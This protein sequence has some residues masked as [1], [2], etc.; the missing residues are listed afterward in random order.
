MVVPNPYSPPTNILGKLTN[1]AKQG[2]RASMESRIEASGISRPSRTSVSLD[3]KRSHL[4]TASPPLTAP[5]L[6]A[7][8]D[9][10]SYNVSHSFYEVDEKAGAAWRYEICVH[11]MGSIEC[12]S[13]RRAAKQLQM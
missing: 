9:R 11:S 5:S 7:R 4:Q 3:S 6:A 12:L 8:A 13:L 10:N 1:H 2:E